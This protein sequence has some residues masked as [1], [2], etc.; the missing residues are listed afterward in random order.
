MESASPCSHRRY[1][2]YPDEKVLS[3]ADQNRGDRANDSIYDDRDPLTDLE[4]SPVF[5]DHDSLAV[6]QNAYEMK[7]LGPCENQLVAVC[8]DFVDD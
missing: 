6:G 1:L 2:I 3:K 8:H 5:F 7:I 4:I